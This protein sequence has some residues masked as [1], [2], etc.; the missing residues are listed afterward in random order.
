MRKTIFRHEDWQK[1]PLRDFLAV[2]FLKAGGDPDLLE[3]LKRPSRGSVKASID[4]GRWVAKCPTHGCGGAIIVGDADPVFWCINCANEENAGAPYRVVFP[5]RALRTQIETF[6]LEQPSARPFAD[7]RRRWEPGWDMARL[8]QFIRDFHQS[9]TAPRTWVLGEIVTA[10]QMNT[11]VRDDLLE[12]APA[13]VTTAGDIVQATAANT[14]ARLGLGT[15]LQIP[16]VN[17][18]VTA[19]EYHTPAAA[20]LTTT[21]VWQDADQNGGKILVYQGSQ[22]GVTTTFAS[23]AITWPVTMTGAGGVCAFFNQYDTD[24]AMTAVM[25]G[26][27]PSTTGCTLHYGL[28]S[29]TSTIVYYQVL[30][31]GV[32]DITP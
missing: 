4:E 14:L 1:V 2:H 16:R 23:A 17:A 29:G 21:A 20:D 24:N 28:V 7:A 18:G 15:A 25:N 30:L 5:A 12:T 31:I 27:N 13:K 8:R 32:P 10:A 11:H 26:R 19:L 9:W 22:A 3:G 6:L